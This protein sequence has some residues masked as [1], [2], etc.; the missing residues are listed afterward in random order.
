MAATLITFDD[1]VQ[2][3]DLPLVPITEKLRFEDVNEIKDAINDNAALTDNRIEKNV[4]ATYTT[5]TVTTLTLAEYN[6]I[7]TPVATTLYFII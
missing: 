4:A 2:G 7:G 3:R 6:A 1:K 5:N